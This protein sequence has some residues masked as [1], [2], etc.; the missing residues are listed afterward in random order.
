MIAFG[1]VPSRRLGQSL[2][3]N[4]IPPKACSYSCVYCQVGRTAVTEIVPR[5]FYSPREILQSVQTRLER[6]AERGEQVDWLTFVPDGEPTLDTTLGETIELL[7]PLGVPIAVI[8][9]SSLVW[10]PDV[11]SALQRADWIS[12][13]V[14]STDAA[15]WRRVNR[16]HPALDLQAI[17]AGIARLA[18]EFHGTLVTET[19]LVAGIN[20]TPESVAGVADYLAE[21]GPATAYLAAPTR[22]P[23]EPDTAPPD[24]ATLVR[25]YQQ[26]SARLPRVET[27]ICDEGDAFASTGRIEDDLL[28]V[29]AVHPLREEAVHAL[30]AKAGAD[31]QAVERLLVAGALRRVEYQGHCFY[32]RR[33]HRPWP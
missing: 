16:P 13:K 14:D 5:A 25:A 7:R 26:L 3:V 15:V 21:I 32:Q 2:G 28:A 10:R 22:P 31:W 6:L 33:L 9:N 18:R 19:M 23:A 30:L 29:T 20:D 12:L 8:T 24:E 1:P 17:L 4:N 27:L 11:R